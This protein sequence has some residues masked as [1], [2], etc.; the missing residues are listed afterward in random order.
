MRKILCL[1]A[2]SLFAATSFFPLSAQ[3]DTDYTVPATTQSGTYPRV[4]R[5]GSAEFRVR[6]T[7]ALKW[8]LSLD[9]DARFVKQADGSWMARTK[10]LV[11]GFHYYWFT[12]DGVDFSDPASHSYYG[13]SRWCSAIDVPESGTDWMLFDKTIAHGQVNIVKYFSPLRN[14]TADLWVYTPAS[15][16]EGSRKYPVLYLQHGGGE[17]ESGWVRQGYTNLIMDNLIAS[18]KAEEMIVVMS[19]G[20]LSVPGMKPAYTKEGMAG[21]GQELI[22]NVIPTVEKNFRVLADREH[23]ALSGLSMGGGQT[24]FVGLSHPELFSAVG[25]F[26]TGL[27]GGIPNSGK[28]FDAEETI[29]GLL[30]NSA[31]YN[32]DLNL[33]YISVGEQDFRISH[34]QKAVADMRAAGLDI[35]FETY[36]GDHEWQVWRKSIHSFAQKVFKKRDQ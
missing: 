1:A 29:P 11:P 15:Y 14:A 31:Q 24:F 9:K 32:K 19:N 12:V 8:V 20:T 18:G 13:C 16:E 36:P 34:T 28:G 4:Y 7:D 17:D 23:R 25:I 33:F 2:I 22:E 5:D 26:S 30:S 27:F 3:T 35:V 21:F 10:P 6:A